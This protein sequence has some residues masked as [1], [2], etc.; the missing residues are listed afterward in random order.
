M[1]NLRTGRDINSFEGEVVGVS[2]EY[3][4]LLLRRHGF[5]L[6]L[7]NMLVS[8]LLPLGPMS[9]NI[10][11]NHTHGKFTFA[12]IYK[13]LGHFGILSSE[14]AN[15]DE[16][17]FNRVAIREYDLRIGWTQ[18]TALPYLAADFGIENLIISM[19]VLIFCLQMLF[20]YFLR[21]NV[22]GLFIAVHCCYASFFLTQTIVTINGQFIIALILLM[23]TQKLLF[24]DKLHTQGLKSK[25]ADKLSSAVPHLQDGIIFCSSP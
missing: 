21:R 2:D 23:Y 25:T 6:L 4:S 14:V 20:L 18:G 9:E 15:E 10:G 1:G 5:P 19:G 22:V 16:S 11:A 13:W 17:V 3:A 24:S 8:R 12:L 7:L